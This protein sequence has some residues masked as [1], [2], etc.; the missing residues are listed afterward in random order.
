LIYA[1]LLQIGEAHV[2]SKNSLQNAIL[3]YIF[4][5]RIAIFRLGGIS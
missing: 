5:E 3:S 4:K 1:T 2:E